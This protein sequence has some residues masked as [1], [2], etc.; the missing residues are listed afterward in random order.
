[1]CTSKI[2]PKLNDNGPICVWLSS[3]SHLRHLAPN[4]AHVH[5]HGEQIAQLEIQQPVFRARVG[6]EL[7]QDL[8]ALLY[9][10]LLEFGTNPHGHDTLWPIPAIRSCPT[11]FDVRRHHAVPRPEVEGSMGYACYFRDLARRK[12]TL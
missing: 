8:F 9:L 12:H 11:C 6:S 5:V 2:C 4:P 7:L 3:P 1:T 10:Q